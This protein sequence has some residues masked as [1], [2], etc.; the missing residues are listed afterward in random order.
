MPKPFVRFLP[1]LLLPLLAGL[2]LFTGSAEL[3]VGE[4]CRALYTGGAENTPAAYIVMQVRLPLLLAALFSGCA[5]AAS[6]LVMQTVFA[7]PLA[8]PS[9]LGVNSGAGLGAAVV[10]LLYGGTFVAGGVSLSGYLLTVIAASAGA[11]AVIVLLMF[12]SVLFRDKLQLLVS[13]VMVNFVASSFIAILG[14]LSTAQGLQNYVFWGMG[15][16]SGVTADRLPLYI[17]SIVG[18][19]L[20]MLG[21]S[22]SLNALLLGNDYAAN[23][24]IRI[25]RVRMRLLLLSGLLCAWVT[26]LCG[27]VS[28]IGLAAPHVARLV[29]RTADHSR[30]MPYTILWGANMA[31]LAV[32]F[33]RLPG[34]V[35][36]PVNAVT[37]LFGVPVV[38]WLLLRRRREVC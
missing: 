30:L 20:L 17:I 14:C 28:F 31:L 11:A 9:L 36:M 24:G 33:T 26:A 32:L 16:F 27:P 22:K 35:L 7:N 2:L 3:P 8:D 6:G 12:L 10:M 29:H 34:G 21:G 4:V 15:D 1:V 38:M 13:G 5:L 23:L 37:P 25:R 19:L 18:C